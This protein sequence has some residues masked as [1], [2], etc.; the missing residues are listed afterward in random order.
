MAVASITGG[1]ERPRMSKGAPGRANPSPHRFKLLKPK[2][3]ST[4]DAAARTTPS[5]SICT[6]GRPAS[7]FSR[8]L[9]KK[10]DGCNHHQH[11]ARRPPAD[12]R[13]QYAPNQKCRHAGTG[14]SR[15]E[16]AQ[17]RGLPPPP[18]VVG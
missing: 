6:W 1:G 14:A 4:M 3:I 11:A 8:K 7:P 2:L 16:R 17:R 12:E 18:L 15:T 10:D 5:P 9:S 13:P